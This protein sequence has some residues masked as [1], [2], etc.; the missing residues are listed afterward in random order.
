MVQVINPISKV[1]REIS[2]SDAT[3]I[4]AIQSIL[5]NHLF[6]PDPKLRP[7]IIEKLLDYLKLKFADEDYKIKFF[8]TRRNQKLSGFLICQIDRE[9]KS[10]SRKC[11]TFGWLYCKDSESCKALLSACEQYINQHRIR[12]IRGPINFPTHIGGIGWQTYGFH[13]PMMAGVAFSDPNSKLLEYLQQLGYEIESKYTC[14]YVTDSAWKKGNKLDPSIK[15][16]FR[17]VEGIRKLKPRIMEI[18]QNSFHSIMADAPGGETKFNTIIM[19]YRSVPDDYYKLR[20][21]LDIESYFKVPEYVE[22]VKECNFEGVVRSAPMA[23]DRETGELVGIIL[24]LP[25]LFQI[26]LGQYPTHINVDTVMIDKAYTRKGIFSALNNIGQ[27]ACNLNGIHYYEGTTIWSNNDRAIKTI[28]PH[29]IPTR[30]H[31]VV[32]K[33]V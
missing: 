9:Y 1:N 24:A 5:D 19:N 28:F 33:R 22:A 6:V 26:W 11:A 16:G 29:S 32:Q 17:D 10:Y 13:N 30:K 21:N 8:I 25:D 18:A 20:S 4:S 2:I 15:L 23:F 31:I 27:L 12:K 3:S 14:V 7:I